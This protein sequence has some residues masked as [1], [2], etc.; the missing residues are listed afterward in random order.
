MVAARLASGCARVALWRAVGRSGFPCLDRIRLRVRRSRNPAADFVFIG[1]VARRRTGYAD[2][3]NGRPDRRNYPVPI[4]RARTAS[5]VV[6]QVRPPSRTTGQ[7]GFAR[8]HI[9][10]HCPAACRIAASRRDGALRSRLGRYS[11]LRGCH[12]GR[13][14]SGHRPIFSRGRY[15]LSRK[16][17]GPSCVQE[18]PS[19]MAVKR[20][21]GGPCA[22][23]CRLRPEAGGWSTTRCSPGLDAWHSSRTIL[24]R[25]G[26]GRQ[27]KRGSTSCPSRRPW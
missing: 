14:A 13:S 9:A 11:P 23:R 21:S 17:K 5:K 12:G 26:R 4:P 25:H 24:R 27:P 22:H 7:L 8:R 18:R 15:T 10:D 3:G 6:E 2:R 1:R 20:V 19:S 16:R